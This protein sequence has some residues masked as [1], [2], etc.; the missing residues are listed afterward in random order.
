MKLSEKYMLFLTEY[1]YHEMLTYL[2]KFNGIYLNLNHV[3]RGLEIQMSDIINAVVLSFSLNLNHF[4][5]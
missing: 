4:P 2:K 1:G 5:T 3:Y